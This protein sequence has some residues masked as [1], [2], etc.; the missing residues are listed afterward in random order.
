MRAISS[1]DL[2]AIAANLTGHAVRK[3]WQSLRTAARLPVRWVGFAAYCGCAG[4]MLLAMGSS[5]LLAAAGRA[6]LPREYRHVDER[7]T[8]V[9]EDILSDMPE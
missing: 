7:L 6:L 2:P 8:T 9:L 5:V 1:Y 4:L 3:S